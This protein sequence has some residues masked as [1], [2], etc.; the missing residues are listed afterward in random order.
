MRG[1]SGGRP[2]IT[3]GD[4]TCRGLWQ[5]NQCNATAFKR[6]TGHPYFWGVLV[7]EYNAEMTSHMIRG[8]VDWSAWSV[9]P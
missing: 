4:G 2:G 1:E 9:Q 8:G 3:N 5:I 7:P 6:I